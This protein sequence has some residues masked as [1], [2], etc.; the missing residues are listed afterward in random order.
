MWSISKSRSCGSCTR[1]HIYHRNLIHL[2]K[3]FYRGPFRTT[4]VLQTFTHTDKEGL[5]DCYKQSM[6]GWRNPH[7]QITIEH[8]ILLFDYKDS[9]EQPIFLSHSGTQCKHTEIVIMYSNTPRFFWHTINLNAAS[10]PCTNQHSVLCRYI[11]LWTYDCFISFYYLF[12]LHG[13]L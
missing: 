5:N 4:N 1:K 6:V 11:C 3:V 8:G 13:V 10:F 2:H 12:I 9:S 7:P